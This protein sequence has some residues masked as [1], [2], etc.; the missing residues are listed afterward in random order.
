MVGC[1]ELVDAEFPLDRA[2]EAMDK[3]D[4]KE[5]TRAALLP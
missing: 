2:A 5:I 1:H 3:S 4:K